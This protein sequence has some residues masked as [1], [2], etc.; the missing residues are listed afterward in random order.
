MPGRTARGDTPEWVTT[1]VF[2]AAISLCTYPEQAV[3]NLKSEC[4]PNTKE[5]QTQESSAPSNGGMT[6]ALSSLRDSGEQK[7]KDEE[8][9]FACCGV[10]RSQVR[11][12]VTDSLAC[13]RPPEETP[14]AKIS[15]VSLLLCA[16]VDL[17]GPI[18]LV[19][20]FPVLGRDPAV[21]LVCSAPHDGPNVTSDKQ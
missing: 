9:N 11:S 12:T 2:F 1:L 18:F 6:L 14:S 8:E 3:H 4:T 15:P 20:R 16:P 19:C 21:S 17:V 5:G 7:T 13:R 10:H